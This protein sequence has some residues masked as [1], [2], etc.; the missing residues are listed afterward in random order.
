MTLSVGW[1]V[2]P[3][4]GALWWGPGSGTVP[5]TAGSVERSKVFDFPALKGSNRVDA[6]GTETAGGDGRN[7]RSSVA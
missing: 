4:V 5:H 7:E 2:Q 6:K 1:N 3:W